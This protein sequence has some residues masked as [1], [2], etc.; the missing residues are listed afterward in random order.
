MR[1]LAPPAVNASL[2]RRS[3]RIVSAPRAAAEPVGAAPPSGP[4][5]RTL[6]LLAAGVAVVGFPAA[7]TLLK[8]LGRGWDDAEN[9]PAPL[10]PAVPPLR[11]ANFAGGCF[12]CVESAF[13]ALPG[14]VAV[15]SGYTGGRTQRPTYLEVC[16]ETTGHKEAV[17]VLYDPRVTT[18]EALLDVYW[19]AVAPTDVRARRTWRCTHPLL[20]N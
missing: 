2:S 8:D 9:A 20:L 17:Q 6:L 19:R 5:R 14:V 1:T 4:S 12:W 13:E 3:R 16:S 7:K 18:Y 10:P 11:T 15:T